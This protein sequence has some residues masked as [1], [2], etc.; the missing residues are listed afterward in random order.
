MLAELQRGN[1]PGV[2]SLEDLIESRQAVNQ[3]DMQ[4]G[5]IARR[6]A[7]TGVSPRRALTAIPRSTPMT[8]PPRMTVRR[9]RRILFAKLQ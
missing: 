4:P 7:F 9:R 8:K 5:D 1:A 3:P 2:E 6:A